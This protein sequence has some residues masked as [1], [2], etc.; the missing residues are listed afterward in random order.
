ML[1]TE[2]GFLL[3]LLPL[4]CAL[5]WWLPLYGRNV[6]LLAVGLVFYWWGEK[7]AL[8]LP[9]SMALNY[10]FGFLVDRGSQPRF[11]RWWLWL[12]LA[13]NLGLLGVYKY[14]E[15]AL[16]SLNALLALGAIPPLVDPLRD[17][18]H[19]PIGI[20]FFTFQGISYLLDVHWGIAR[21]HRDPVLVGLYVSLFP[22][23]IAGPIVKF[24]EISRQL[25]E[26]STSEADLHAGVERFVVGFAK[27]MLLANPLAATADIAFGGDPGL[28][29]PGAAWLG[30]VCYALQ[31]YFDFSGYSDM[32]IGV[33]RVFGFRI[34]ENFDHPFIA[35][36]VTEVWQ[37]WHMTLATWLRD[38]VYFPLIGKGRPGQ[39]RQGAALFGVF[40][41]CGLWHG[42][43]WNFVLWGAYNGVFLV[44]ERGR[45]GG[46]LKGLW[47]PFQHGYA[48][49]FWLAACVL[50]RST[51][52]DHAVHYAGSLLGLVQLPSA[53]PAAALLDG[54]VLL[55]LPAALLA[56]LPVRTWLTTRWGA[57]PAFRLLRPAVL[58][59]CFLAA[60]LLVLGGSYNPFLYFQF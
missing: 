22:H 37:R 50:F 34:P 56:C 33:A 43:S 6:L 54:Q 7:L 31:L 18:I 41:L 2:P 8:L 5:H 20:S 57:H 35:R 49:A 44:L 29:G 11:A 26:R 39:A 23:Q 46:W 9:V 48:L 38:Y 40:L 14:A 24:K 16:D 4:L 28:L 58:G 1:F 47:R 55:V 12:G 51:D 3:L 19:L 45:F 25:A 21:R 17:R 52:L 60:L 42:A 10:G 15:F 59:A 53:A 27:K 32:A 13:A 36:S 30:L